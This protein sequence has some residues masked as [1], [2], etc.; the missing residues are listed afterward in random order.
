VKSYLKSPVILLLSI[1]WLVMGCKQLRP[2]YYLTPENYPTPPG[3]VSPLPTSGIAVAV[4]DDASA[5]PDS[6][7]QPIMPPTATPPPPTITSTPTATP[8]RCTE[9]EGKIEIM[10]FDSQITGRAFGYR[11]YLPPCYTITR[12]RYP[13]L[14]MMHGL[15]PGTDVMNDDQWDRMGL[16][17]A[18]SQGYLNG[19]LAPMI[20]IMPDGN[21]A[22][23]GDDDSPFSKVIV[24]ELM[25][26]VEGNLCTWN[27]S[28]MR[29]IGGLSRGGFW[30]YSVAYQD[31]SLFD[32]VGGH[33]PFFYDGDYKVY[34]PY[35]L[36]DTAQGIVRLK[37]YIDYGVDD[38]N[39]D[40]G[41]EL[42]VD[43]LRSQGIEPQL[44]INPEGAHTEDYW[45]AH[46]ADYLAFYAAEWLHAIEDLPGCN[47]PSP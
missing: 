41:I 23:H 16:D 40:T 19:T 34:N 39:V 12:R 1:T 18:A 6:T 35:N 15:V 47:Q 42:F 44:V 26:E 46:V 7:I 3:T 43:K 2:G 17:E 29:A 10:S 5:T 14:I 4:A 38:H 11:V 25:P 8:F 24:S 27:E 20:I 45:A 30:A 22:R 33:S 21:D 28:R 31:T 32:R 9:T 37:M 13:Y 36:M